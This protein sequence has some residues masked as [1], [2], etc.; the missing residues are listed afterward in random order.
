MIIHSPL[1]LQDI[2]L[3]RGSKLCF[4]NFS[5]RIYAG[6]RIG[7]LGNNGVGKS[8]LL[9]IIRGTLTDYA[10]YVDTT[11]NVDIGYV[12]QLIETPTHLSGAERFQKALSQVYHKAPNLL[13]LD[14]PTN[15]L[16]TTRRRSLF[17]M[18]HHYPG[19]LLIVTHDEALLRT[20]IEKLWIL[21]QGHI[22]VFNGHYDDY[23]AQQALYARQQEA[24]Y[25]DL[26]KEKKNSIHSRCA[27]KP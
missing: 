14:E 3:Y 22:H 7:I 9:A 1:V 11:Q 12:P 25:H 16:D 15:H 4:S 17:K 23:L 8:A 21:E 6:D 5:T 24:S 10:G 27:H 26:K 18:L 20:R 19:T 2:T 13:L